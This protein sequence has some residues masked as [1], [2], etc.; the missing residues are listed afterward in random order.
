[1]DPGLYFSFFCPYSHII[2]SLY[3]QYLLSR[4]ARQQTLR[5][6]TENDVGIWARIIK[7]AVSTKIFIS[8]PVGPFKIWSALW[9]RLL[10]RREEAKQGIPF[11]PLNPAQIWAGF[12]VNK[13]FSDR[14]NGKKSAVASWHVYCVVSANK[15]T[16]MKT[17]RFSVITLLLPT[18]Q[19]TRLF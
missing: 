17:Q 2:L 9:R 7:Q 16:Q 14:R 13:L 12:Q 10:S 6:Q 4:Q 18:G 19:P 1:M 15:A 3:A 11:W 5:I 8:C